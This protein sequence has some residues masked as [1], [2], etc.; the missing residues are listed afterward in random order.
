M[1]ERFTKNAIDMLVLCLIVI[2]I[3]AALW[4]AIPGIIK[5][6]AVILVI[7]GFIAMLKGK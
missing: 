7:T 3:A 1:F 2:G 6:L 4:N 5:I